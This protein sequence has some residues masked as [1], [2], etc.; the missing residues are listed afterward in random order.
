[1]AIYF[2]AISTE[3]PM[4]NMVNTPFKTFEMNAEHLGIIGT[5]SLPIVYVI[6]LT[7]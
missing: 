7:V 6:F 3:E 1:M 5:V 2:I 4:Q